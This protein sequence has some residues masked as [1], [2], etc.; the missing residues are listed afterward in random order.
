M[1]DDSLPSKEAYP[2]SFLFE[3]SADAVFLLNQHRRLLRVN[4][5]WEELTGLKNA[6]VRGMACSRRSSAKHPSFEALA[7]ALG[8]PAIVF[9][10]RPVRV[11]RRL[12][13][14]GKSHVIAD[15]DFWPVRDGKNRLRILGKISV[16]QSE[17]TAAV[18]L[19]DA[20]LASRER[21]DASFSFDWLQS[22]LPEM[23]RVAEQARL[24]AATQ[25]PV[26][27]L[28]ETGTGK[29]CLAR[30]IHQLGATRDRFFASISPRRLPPDFVARSLFGHPGYGT[31]PQIGTLYLADVDGLPRDVQTQVLEQ[32]FDPVRQSPR[33]IA[34]SS[35]D[36]KTHVRNQQFVPELYER[37]Q[38]LTIHLPP[39]RKRLADLPVL[40]E[41]LLPRLLD[42]APPKL[43]SAA[44][45]LLKSYDWPGNLRELRAVFVAANSRAQQREIDARDFPSY[46]RIRVE[47]DSDIREPLKPLVLDEVLQRVECQLIEVALKRANGNKTK[48]AELLSIWRPRL[49]RRME[50]LKIEDPGH[51]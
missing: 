4:A 13:L 22:E 20:I 41:V 50:A 29:R 39:L 45:D 23:Q 28:G 32:F 11:Q 27:I 42:V 35:A 5:A 1:R 3:R 15:I 6:D 33:L 36:L 19:P 8:P 49:L 2:W 21:Y 9:D 16:L 43:T 25:I 24:A 30:L 31:N 26:L 44:W 18:I 17:P 48:A 38:V 10:G 7:S 46:L 40:V 37:L 34:G 14:P 51:G 12:P 47:A